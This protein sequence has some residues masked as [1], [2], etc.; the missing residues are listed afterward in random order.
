M[1]K[2]KIFIILAL[3]MAFILCVAGCGKKDDN[4]VPDYDYEDDDYDNDDD[5]DD[6]N[7]DD[8]DEETTKKVNTTSE[9]EEKTTE[10]DEVT[11]KEEETTPTYTLSVDC[12]TDDYGLAGTYTAI[13]SKS[14]KAG[15]KIELVATVN[16]G[17]NFKGWYAKGEDHYW[18]EEDNVL[19]S[20]ELSFTYTMPQKDVT[21]IPVFNYYTVST[22]SDTNVG[23]VAGTYTKMSN[24][25]LS[26]GD[27]V[28]L[29]ATV[30][31][32]HNFEGWYIDNVCVSKNL[33]YTY[34]MEEESVTINAKFS[35]YF[36]TVQGSLWMG[37][38]YGTFSSTAGSCTLYSDECFSDGESITLT[39]T[40]KDGYNFEGWY[41]GNT[42]LST[43]LEY[44]YVMGK[45]DATIYAEFSAYT[46]STI[47]VAVDDDGDTDTSFNAGTY[48][49]Y[50]G[51][52]LSEG[53]TVTLTATVN[54][55]YNFEGWY[56]GNNCVSTDFEYTYTMGKD[57]VTVKA[58]Y[59]YYI[60][61]VSAKYRSWNENRYFDTPSLY[62][63]QVYN[64][65]KISAGTSITVTAY[66]I[67]GYTFIGWETANAI[68]SHDKTYTF[69]MP[70]DNLYL[71]ARYQSD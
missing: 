6:D 68:L 49:Q 60:L 13:N 22:T 58:R 12:S 4:F 19:L 67:D 30:N 23:N 24:K 42:C 43:D 26:V 44:T 20:E 18:Y 33:N 47:G 9:D 54:D 51:K 62:I 66:D 7:Y 45:E 53:T 59:R 2:A 35:T 56:I 11:T 3:C 48:T 17:Y 34:T 21:I 5:D 50:S 1:K 32:G 39:A 69:T 52:N 28:S 46:F 37:E 55:G 25:K 57:N 14:Y 63:S 40:V 71:H 70:N 8:D 16:D 65:Q 36:L 41:I 29:I 38:D 27:T 61:D 64:E 15:D 10:D 31:E